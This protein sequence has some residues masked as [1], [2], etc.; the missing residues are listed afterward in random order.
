MLCPSRSRHFNSWR[1]RCKALL[2]SG[3]RFGS[4]NHGVPN[5]QSEQALMKKLIFIIVFLAVASVMTW[6]VWL[7]P[8]RQPGEETK[9]EADVPV[10]V[11]TISR[12]SLRSYV[13]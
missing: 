11:T 2:V 12:T 10:H 7:R 3:R 13:T 6:L 5:P 8:V 9:P 1:M 4:T